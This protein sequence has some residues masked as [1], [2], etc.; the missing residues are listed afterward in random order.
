M[1]RLVWWLALLLV[2]CQPPQNWQ[3]IVN[4]PTPLPRGGVLTY[5]LDEDLAVFQPWS[6]QNRAA[7]VVAS[8]TQSGLTRL[9]VRGQPQ[10]ELAESWQVDQTGTVVT[11]T[12]RNDLLW[13]DGQSLSTNDVVYSYQALIALNLQTP[14]GRELTVIREVVSTSP[15]IVEFRLNQPYSPVLT[16]WALPILPRHVLAEQALDAV[17]LRTLTVGAGP[18]VMSQ[19]AEN[20]EW[21]LVANQNYHRGQ[22]LFDGVN[23]RLNQSSDALA[24]LQASDEP[25]VIDTIQQVTG[26]ESLQ[27]SYP[28]N[29][30]LSVAFNMRAEKAMNSLPLRHELI[31]LAELDGHFVQTQT[32]LLSVRQ[33]TMPGNWLEVPELNTPKT[34]INEQLAQQGWQ[35]DSTTQ[36]LVRN[37]EPLRLTMVVQSENPQ[38]DAL[39]QF[40]TE[41]WQKVGIEITRVDVTRQQYLERLITPY[42]F[43]VA[44]VEW[45]QG[46]SDARYADTLLYDPTAYWLFASD[47]MNTG[48]PDT[49]GSLNVVGMNDEGYDMLYK[50][51]LATYDM[52]GRLNAERNASIRISDVAPYYFVA[53][54][55][56]NVIRSAR[57]A[58][59]N[60]LPTFTTPWYLSTIDVWYRLP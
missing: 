5:A 12:L 18:F 59:I 15:T 52:V 25:F 1:K 60:E 23:V 27:S 26:N 46:R 51:A 34:A 20:G 49:R 56:R 11:V 30:L 44:I 37:G 3:E 53:R 32:Q 54:Q 58:S 7:E 29:T 45:A 39:A 31:R 41:K 4:L 48:M 47:E 40:L 36:Q 13:S 21:Q 14:L 16:L 9:D 28:L 42:D 8:L 6:L 50:S 10:P 57:L 22:P 19:I 17:N 33:V 2:A 35:Y 43:D 55:Q 24:V 38:H